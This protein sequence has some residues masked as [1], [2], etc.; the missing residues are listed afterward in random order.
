MS[1][2]SMT[3]TLCKSILHGPYTVQYPLKPKE[4]YERT[5]GRI[6]IEINDCIFCGMCSRR[7]PTGAITINKPNQTWSIERLSCIQCNYCGEVCPKKC[8]HMANEYTTP[9]YDKVRDE[10]ARVSDNQE[11]N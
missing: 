4:K 5:R 8:L 10:Y 11:N 3:K 6:E 1:I 7:C 9:S 2:F